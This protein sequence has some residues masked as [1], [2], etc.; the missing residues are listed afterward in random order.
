MSGSVSGFV[1]SKSELKSKV[2]AFMELPFQC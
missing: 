2:S 1:G